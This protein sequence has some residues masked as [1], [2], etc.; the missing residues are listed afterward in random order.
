MAFAFDMENTIPNYGNFRVRKLSFLLFLLFS[1]VS[2]VIVFCFSLLDLTASVIDLLTDFGEHF[3]ILP[4]QTVFNVQMEL[5]FGFCCFLAFVSPLVAPCRRLL[6]FVVVFRLPHCKFSGPECD[7]CF[8]CQSKRLNRSWI[9]L[10][11]VLIKLSFAP[12]ASAKS[13]NNIRSNRIQI[14]VNLNRSASNLIR[15]WIT[16]YR[17]STIYLPILTFVVL[18]FSG[19]A[20]IDSSI[21]E[22][23]VVIVNALCAHFSMHWLAIICQVI[24]LDGFS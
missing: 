14:S 1:A 23:M 19:V 10:Y 17:I 20:G 24:L 22:E 2:L 12:A 6:S 4:W 18:A 13:T 15:R 9:A 8:E 21:V 5:L 3:A 16:P 7:I 11:Y